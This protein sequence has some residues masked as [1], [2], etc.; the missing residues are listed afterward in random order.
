MGVYNREDQQYD[1]TRQFRLNNGTVW[2][3][4][5]SLIFWLRASEGAGTFFDKSGNFASITSSGSGH[6]NVSDSPPVKFPFDSLRLDNK[7][8]TV[9]AAQAAD[10]TDKKSLIFSGWVYLNVSPALNNKGFCLLHSTASTGFTI[11][12]D[13]QGRLAIRLTNKNSGGT[14][15]SAKVQTTKKPFTAK[16]WNHFVIEVRKEA[17]STA[18]FKTAGNVN[19]FVNGQKKAVNVPSDVGSPNLDPKLAGTS[20]KIGNGPAE[21][22]TEADVQLNGKL[23]DIFLL[24]VEGNLDESVIR[25]LYTATVKGAKHLG[26]GFLS[27]TPFN[28]A[29]DAFLRQTHPTVARSSN[30]GRTG[31]HSTVFDDTRAIHLTNNS[32]TNFP[33]MLPAE[34][35]LFQTIYNGHV[36]GQLTS[37]AASASFGIFDEYYEENG[38]VAIKPFIESKVYID[39]GSTFYQTGTLDSVIPGFDQ[40]LRQKQQ[41]T[42]TGELPITTLGRTDGGNQNVGTT[43]NS[44]TTVSSSLM[45]YVNKYGSTRRLRGH[46]GQ[47]F[48]ATESAEQAC[49]GFAYPRTFGQDS[50][51]QDI[52]HSE[53][54]TGHNPTAAEQKA[55]TLAI[56]LSPLPDNY[57]SAYSGPVDNYRFP[58]DDRYKANPGE[59]ISMS[60]YITEPFLCEKIVIELP[61]GQAFTDRQ[62]GV[63]TM[64]IQFIPRGR[65]IVGNAQNPAQT[66][67]HDPV[68]IT[69]GDVGLSAFLLV[70]SPGEHKSILTGSITNHYTA[71]G[72]NGGANYPVEMTITGSQVRNILT[73][74]TALF[75]N[76]WNSSGTEWRGANSSYWSMYDHGHADRSSANVFSPASEHFTFGNFIGT[77]DTPSLFTTYLSDTFEKIVHMGH[78]T[79]QLT[80]GT[81]EPLKFELTPRIAK[82]AGSRDAIAISSMGQASPVTS[83]STLNQTWQ[84]GPSNITEEQNPRLVSNQVIGILNTAEAQITTNISDTPG[85]RRTV[86][87]SDT[88]APLEA[89]Y[90]LLPT[91]KLV[92]GLQAMAHRSENHAPRAGINLNAGEW[93]I[94]LF[95]STIAQDTPK[96][97]SYSQNLSTQTVHEHIGPENPTDI[98]H[99][100]VK[101]SYTGSFSDDVISGSDT[102]STIY[103][104]YDAI[105]GETINLARRVIGRATQGTQGETGALKRYFRISDSKERL[106]DSVLPDF[107]KVMMVDNSSSAI[108]SNGGVT[109]ITIGKASGNA[110]W[111]FA[112]PFESRYSGIGRSDS[113]TI[114]G[115]QTRNP[116]VKIYIDDD[117][118]GIKSAE[119]DAHTGAPLT[120]SFIVPRN[121]ENAKADNSTGIK[122]IMT[123]GDALRLLY[124]IGA[125][126][127]GIYYARGQDTAGGRIGTGV[128]A[129]SVANI[130]GYKYGIENSRP[131]YTS[132]VF[133][134]DS[135]GQF[136]DLLEPRYNVASLIDNTITFPVEQKFF[137][138]NGQPL[139]KDQR[140]STNSSNISTNATSSLPFFDRPNDAGPLN[141]DAIGPI[142]PVN[143]SPNFAPGNGPF[144]VDQ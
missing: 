107:G 78:A 125:E 27:P 97:R 7:F 43:S 17:N 31:N 122:Q 120:G 81:F 118:A 58:D 54:E 6:L 87:L 124:G 69:S 113:I 32:A 106:Y 74:G 3:Y 128:R 49:I 143:I 76:T 29:N 75:Y 11:F 66:D 34:N 63:F 23:A 123:E 46:F 130:A 98:Q 5:S 39:S 119:L 30:D 56:T 83:Y 131:C 96:R 82:K 18:N 38:G 53:L 16:K 141:R 68:N 64:G 55:S 61:G 103:Q 105:T 77:I 1:L 52:T 80:D 138:R 134:R 92:F 22:E 112:F 57:Y 109:S 99:I 84:G 79:S 89:Q 142:Q 2:S 117:S 44:R 104:G 86:I 51:R 71:Y 12:I 126:P 127:R 4:S 88:I 91:D 41:I 13:D 36:N 14:L 9:G 35:Q 25:A 48:K 110:V 108:V 137:T 132:A 144:L 65:G 93:K 19:I 47:T 15:A 62:S 33:S 59:Q 50:G 100:T 45:S 42:I 121:S 94:T 20:Y 139:A 37:T 73:F 111:P 40:P 136:R 102:P 26:S 85:E 115:S 101:R 133:R 60:D 140:S 70:Q 72:F 95:G 135:F 21:D 114:P 129:A 8:V 67:R 24:Q 28:L 10:S 116:G 90:L